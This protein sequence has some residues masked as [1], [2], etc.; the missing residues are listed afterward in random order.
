MGGES[1]K[2]ASSTPTGA[3]FLSYASEDAEAAQR[4][5][6]ALTAAGIEV[7]FDQSELRGGD[8]WDRRIRERI[9]DCRLFIALISV[10]TEAR[11]EGYFRR[12]WSLAAD[13]TRDMAYKR[14]FL[15][16]VVIDG[17]LERGASVP[18]KFH[19]LQWTRLPDGET[20]PAFVARIQKLL[21]PDVPTQVAAAA[22]TSSRSTKAPASK[23][24][25]HPN[26]PSNVVLWLISALL[27][28]ALAYLIAESLWR[29]QHSQATPASQKTISSTSVVPSTAA[30]FTPP[31]HS[32]A[33]LPFVNLSGDKEQEYFSDGLTE[34]LLNSLAEI[35]GLQVAARTSSFSFRQH[36]DIATVAHKLNVGAVLEGSVRRSGNTVRVTTQL[37]NAVSGFHL[38]SKTYD[39][40]LGDVLK[41]Q[42]EIATAVAS[43][44]KVALLGSEAAKIEAG[45]THN[46]AALDAYL[47]ATKTLFFGTSP[48]DVKTAVAGYTDAIGLD[49]DY[50]LAYAGRSLAVAARAVFLDVTTSAVHAD[51]DKAQADAAKAIAL[52]P[53][54]S[55]GYLARANAHE[56]LLE[57]K[58]ASQDYE[59]A[60]AL[61]PGNARVL[62]D[63]GDFA[64]YMGH[65]DSGL[66][67]IRR[68]VMLDPLN[69]NSHGFLGGALLRLRRYAEALAATK[70]A[71]ALYSTGPQLSLPG[72]IGT[73]YYLLGDFASARA[74]CEQDNGTDALS[75]SCLALA[76]DKL[77]R[78]ADA[79][80]E[81]KKLQ[82]A[83]GDGGAYKYAAIYAQWG[84]HA[85]ALEWLDFAM[86]R[87]APGLIAL[88]TDPLMDPL[89]QEPRFQAV[90]R[91]LKF[92]Q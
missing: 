77:G 2:P 61:A 39:R 46:P 50:A 69:P 91:E 54:L 55:E 74:T 19:E 1:P 70:Q 82:A 32:I 38:W 80:A 4:I 73:T 42:T 9:H 13:R 71:E 36:P 44:L 21:V 12:E 27:V 28:V 52:A 76:Y 51:F 88:K 90:L 16:P 62:R 5:C 15:V 43:A 58:E 64:V 3:V 17:T 34:E 23:P 48:N 75:H 67:A 66:T 53:D 85:K 20:T 29:P 7:W 25:L 37:I 33:V 31:P 83:S 78:H 89:R 87:R 68:A 45:G 18:E 11:D 92:P 60:L 24:S 57:F 59:H 14:A 41:L 56:F 22:T 84:N 40:D 8:A 79:E 26:W 10:H 49:P 86:G 81:L 65:G 63:Y 72:Q 47:R 35:E 30:A 6:T